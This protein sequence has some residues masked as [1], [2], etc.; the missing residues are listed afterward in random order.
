MSDE[1]TPTPRPGGQRTLLVMA[2][3]AVVALAAGLGLSRLIVS[4]A[5]AAADAEPPAAGPITV[6]VES[7]V[8]ANDVTLRGDA[9]YDDATD[10][11]IEVGAVEGTP[12][13]TGQV[14]EVGATL[15]AASVALEIVGRP[16]IVLPGELPTYRTL[17]QGVSGP[18]VAQLKTALGSLGISAGDPASD[19]Y[20]ATVAAGVQELYR[21]VGYAAPSA[22]EDQA[23]AVDAGRDAV[24]GAEEAL[25]SARAALTTASKGTT[26]QSA[27]VAADAAIRAAEAGL[28][29]ANARLAEAQAACASPTVDPDSGLPVPCRQSDLD[30]AQADVVTAQG[31]LDVARAQRTEVDGNR[32]DTTEARAAVASAERALADAKDDL[33][34]AQLA[35]LTPLPANEV[36]F[37]PS[38]PRRV[39]AV[40]VERGGTVTTGAV[41]SVSGATL[42]IVASASK[43]DAAL[44]E[45]GTVGHITVGDADLEVT[46]TEITAA[47]PSSGGGEGGD[48]G[49]G[50][51]TDAGRSTVTLLPGELT[52]EQLTEL[53]GSNVRVKIPVSSTGGEVLAVP[54][55]A[56]TAGPGG[57]SRIELAAA[58]GTT[59][60]VDVTTGLAAGGFVEISS[61]QRT[62]AAG[63]LVVVGVTGSGSGSGGAPTSGATDG[64]DDA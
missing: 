64:G 22:S 63:D 25:A 11:R 47:T 6:P 27:V 56:L 50:G 30:S 8:I 41:M 59:E 18:D 17:R 1:E 31:A 26:L 61:T 19:V 39:D 12:V 3:V 53:Q 14:P 55:A 43:A 16:V 23:A 28:T 37:L 5:Q 21:R 57:E 29:T 52:P 32:P 48:G 49:D 40:S 24:R 13:V 36:V 20:D 44:L 9:T 7:R 58:D 62:L 2:I 38:L 51:G 4:P 45:V 35:T 33:A 46:V 10:L 54:L 34:Q 42:E 15:D 60:L